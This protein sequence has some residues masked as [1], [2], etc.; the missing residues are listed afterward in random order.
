MA[1]RFEWPC[2]IC[3]A[4]V[5]RV[6]P[7]GGHDGLGLSRFW[8]GVAIMNGRLRIVRGRIIDPSRALDTVGDVIV[9][10][11]VVTGITR[12]SAPM[13][14]ETLVDAEGCVVAPGFIDLHTHLREPGFEHQETLSTGGRA[15]AAGGFTTVCATPD[16]DP[17]VDTGSDVESVLSAARKTSP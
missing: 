2:C 15:A 5:H 7:K 16:T 13:D 1:S 11:G 8:R 3:C 17:T 6:S 14:G 9:E 10:R 4:P 12:S